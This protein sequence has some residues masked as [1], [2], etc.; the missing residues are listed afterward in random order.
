MKTLAV[1][2]FLTMLVQMNNAQ[3]GKVYDN[4]TMESKILGMERKYA[5]YTPPDYETSER[6]YPVL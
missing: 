6:S 2:I 1:L 3:H 5:V 4:L